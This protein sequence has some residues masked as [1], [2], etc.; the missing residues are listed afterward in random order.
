[1]EKKCV[2]CVKELLAMLSHMKTGADVIRYHDA[3]R[4]AADKL[5]TC[6]LIRDVDAHL[7]HWYDHQTL[8][9]VDGYGFE[10]RNPGDPIRYFSSY[11]RHAE[12]TA[13]SHALEYDK[14]EFE[15]YVKREFELYVNFIRDPKTLS[16]FES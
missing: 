6:A 7:V 11:Y 5:P 4:V 13:L 8:H 14:R 15:L 12:Q 10:G 16:P 3:I 2:A 9:G 1:M